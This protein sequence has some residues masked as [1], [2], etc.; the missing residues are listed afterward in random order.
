MAGP[1]IILCGRS[2]VSRGSLYLCLLLTD[3]TVTSICRSKTPNIKVN[4]NFVLIPAGNTAWTLKSITDPSLIYFLVKVFSLL[5]TT[6]PK[7][8][9]IKNVHISMLI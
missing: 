1:K 4:Y 5:S 9:A 3:S 8:M 2:C 7:I 6:P